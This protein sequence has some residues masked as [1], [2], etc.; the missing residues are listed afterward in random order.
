MG[1]W[2]LPN[3]KE[4]ALKLQELMQ[5]PL[6]ANKK[7]TDKLYDLYGDDNLFDDISDRRYDYGTSYDLRFLVATYLN[8]T[9]EYYKKSPEKFNLKFDKEAL[10]ILE[11]IVREQ[12]V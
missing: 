8:N 10:V 1:T 2:A 12:G 9:I 7:V 5:K 6:K 4:K 3:T 11:N